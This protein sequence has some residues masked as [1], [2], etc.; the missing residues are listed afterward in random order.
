MTEF[1]SSDT[2]VWI[3][4]DAINTIELPFKLPCTYIM[5]HEAVDNEVRSPGGLR[6]KLL[7]AGLVAVE[8]TGEEFWLAET[9]ADRYAQISNYDAIALSIARTRNISLMAGDRHLRKAA[10]EEGVT[11]IGTIGV[12]DRLLA[13]GRINQT[14]YRRSIHALLAVNGGVV[15][16]PESEL[17]K[18]L[19][20]EAQENP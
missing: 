2:N 4:F 15:R 16:L 20:P 13:E 9:Y 19:K 7:A 8:I 3:D 18:R 17:K 1:I 14:E 11:V 10:Q 12:L 6:E 5:F